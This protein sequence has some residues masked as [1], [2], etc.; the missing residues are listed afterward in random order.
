MYMQIK[1]ILSLHTVYV[2]PLHKSSLE[3]WES[4]VKTTV[5]VAHSDT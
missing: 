4:E 3:K 1:N 2:Q 5:F